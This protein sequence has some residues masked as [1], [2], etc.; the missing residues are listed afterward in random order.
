VEKGEALERLGE[1]FPD[2]RFREK[3]RKGGDEDCGLRVVGVDE[4]GEI[5][6][7]AILEYCR[8]LRVTCGSCLV[9][10]GWNEGIGRE[11]N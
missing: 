10:E 8:W 3:G 4:V 6:S 2:E 5:S 7:V 1:Q 9:N 11:K